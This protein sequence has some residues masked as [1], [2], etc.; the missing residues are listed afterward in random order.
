M[1]SGYEYERFCANYIKKIGFYNIEVTKSSGDQGVDIVASKGGHRY[2]I[3]CKYYSSPVGNKA[4]Q[5]VVAGAA[6]YNCDKK[7]VITNSSFTSSAIDLAASNGVE[8]L[9]FVKETEIRSTF[10]A[11]V[12]DLGRTYGE[13]THRLPSKEDYYAYSL[14]LDSEMYL[15]NIMEIEKDYQYLCHKN[16]EKYKPTNSYH[17]S[18]MNFL[19]GINDVLNKTLEDFALKIIQ[20]LLNDDISV[21]TTRA[22]SNKGTIVIFFYSKFKTLDSIQLQCAQAHLN[23]VGLICS[24]ET[25]KVDDQNFSLTISKRKGLDGKKEWQKYLEL[26]RKY[27]INKIS[28]NKVLSYTDGYFSKNYFIELEKNV[29]EQ[30]GYYMLFVQKLLPCEFIMNPIK[31]CSAEYSQNDGFLRFFYYCT[32]DLRFFKDLRYIRTRK[33]YN[34]VDNQNTIFVMVASV[35]IDNYSIMNRELSYFKNISQD[36]VHFEFM[37]KALFNKIHTSPLGGG[38]VHVHPH[39]FVAMTDYDKNEE[40]FEI[41][42]EL[43]RLERLENLEGLENMDNM[44]ES[45]N[46]DDSANTYY[47]KQ[48]GYSETRNNTDISNDDFDA[49][50]DFTDLG[51]F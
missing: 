37:D 44:D 51:D 5:E 23:S 48:S 47:S 2:A 22:R 21:E 34:V 45:G 27:Y 11:E 20:N 13:Y 38:L 4:V 35:F 8:L 43:D 42:E 3:Q 10:P 1:L 29:F 6:F 39:Y 28:N 12:Y 36:D 14:I 18:S 46:E 33:K 9:P 49:F 40:Y 41:Q 19:Y 16:L 15:K 17:S 25:H 50:K 32:I 26:K 7:M 30:L 31:L 24:F